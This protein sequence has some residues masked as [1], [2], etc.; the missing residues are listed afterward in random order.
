MNKRGL[1]TRCK[2]TE[3]AIEQMGNPLSET[4]ADLLV[5]NS[6]NIADYAARDKMKQIEKLGLD[7][8]VTYAVK[9]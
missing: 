7:Q 4:S 3:E 6:R 5:L 2:I 8:Y 9:D 1:C